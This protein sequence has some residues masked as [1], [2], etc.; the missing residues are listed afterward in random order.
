M[1]EEVSVR[2]S[3]RVLTPSFLISFYREQPQ[4]GPGRGQRPA[5]GPEDPGQAGEDQHR[6]GGQEPQPGGG[7]QH[8]EDQGGDPAGHVGPEDGRDGLPGEG[9]GETEVRPGEPGAQQTGLDLTYITTITE[10][11]KPGHQHEHFSTTVVNTG[12]L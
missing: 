3:E 2:L 8:A 1:A 6:P 9:A 11:N 12:P 5:P 10:R 7:E 4:S